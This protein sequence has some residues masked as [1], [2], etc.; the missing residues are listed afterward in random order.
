MRTIACWLSLILVGGMLGGG[1]FAEFVKE[2]CELKE[3]QVDSGVNDPYSCG[4][5]SCPP[6]VKTEATI[7]RP[8]N[9]RVKG[10]MFIPSGGIEMI[11]INMAE[12]DIDYLMNSRR[13]VPNVDAAHAIDPVHV[14]A[15]GKWL[16]YRDGGTGYLIDTSGNGKTQATAHSKNGCIWRGRGGQDTI[17][18]LY[19]DSGNK[20]KARAYDVSSGVPER[21][22]GGEDWLV[23]GEKEGS[24]SSTW[25]AGGTDF[26]IVQERLGGD[27]YDRGYIYKVPDGGTA[28]ADDRFPFS[29]LYPAQCNF[30]VDMTGTML[31]AN[32]GH[33]YQ[34]CVP[35]NHK[36]PVLMPI[37]EFSGD[38]K[39]FIADH[40]ISVNWCPT[41]YEGKNLRLGKFDQTPFD[42]WT[43]TNDSSYIVC[44]RPTDHPSI[45]VY[46][47]W[48]VNWRTN[49]W[50]KLPT[51]SS[52]TAKQFAVHISG[53]RDVEVERTPSTVRRIRR[54]RTHGLTVWRDLLGREV[55][56]VPGA[57]AKSIRID[58]S[59]NKVSN[60]NRRTKR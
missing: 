50:T 26:V 34:D 55:N 44:S 56:T 59:G 29:K 2:P 35:D 20:I 48:L 12:Y 38:P 42:H 53:P 24:R 17:W 46:G 36:G 22:D 14:S 41:D 1:V 32:F 11:D 18:I 5:T 39:D 52:V 51:F 60:I 23:L 10:T 31:A 40:A 37:E 30:T 33:G 13:M 43:W 15:D 21:A 7:V 16:F 54:D 9:L 45:N 3:A 8:E 4:S 6:H 57:S 25:M 58:E 19:M 47:D 27:T 49:E 28:D